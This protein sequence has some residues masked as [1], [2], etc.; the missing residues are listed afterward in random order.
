M[1]GI[2]ILILLM[3]F[4]FIS[5]F[6]PYYLHIGT[7]SLIYALLSISWSIMAISGYISLG[8]ASFF[9][10]GCY[11]TSILSVSFHLPP[12]ITILI[13]AILSSIGGGSIL[14]PLSRMGRGHFPLL[15]FAIAGILQGVFLVLQITGGPAGIKNIPPFWTLPGKEHVV[16]YYIA[17]LVFLAAYISYRVIWR[18]GWKKVIFSLR[19]DELMAGALG[20]RKGKVI[21][22]VFLFSSFFAGMG[23]ALYAHLIGTV[24]PA[25]AFNIESTIKPLIMSMVG[26]IMHMNGPVSGAVMVYLVEE[27]LIHPLIPGGY[28]ILYGTLLIIY[29]SL[30]PEG[31][32]LPGMEYL[33]KGF[34]PWHYL[35]R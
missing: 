30:A 32:V 23:G 31:I 10:L 27:L 19:D 34:K 5:F 25:T 9:G 8:L 22:G 29:I 28:L 26:G 33:R 7:F 17:L 3:L 20:V 14:Y 24:D 16:D 2:L 21:F 18:S 12:I 1:A 6:N 4:P 13:S 15:T 11:L 35:K